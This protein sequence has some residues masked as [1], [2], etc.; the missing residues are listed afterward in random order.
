[1]AS[2][3]R[4]A[5]A[6]TLALG[7]AALA[8]EYVTSTLRRD[9]MSARVASPA[10]APPPSSES[11]QRA[12]SPEPTAV[13]TLKVPSLVGDARNAIAWAP[14]SDPDDV[15]VEGSVPRS[16]AW[17][18]SK[19]LVIA[20]YLGTVVGGDPTRIPGQERIWIRDALAK[21]DGPAI[22]A[23]KARIPGGPGPAMTRILRSVGDV[24]TVAPNSYEGTMQWTVREQVRFMA[25]LG[26][27][28][29]VSPAASA[30][31]LREMQP[32]PE[33]RW[34]LGSI[35]ARAFKPGWLRAN[36][37]TRQMGI[38]GN[39]AVAI[40]TAGDGPAMLQGDGDYAHAA[41]MDRLAGIVAARIG[42]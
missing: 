3:R 8:T 35:G 11:A 12:A 41:Q 18:T 10:Y 6:L 40:I 9:T 23:I 27:G 2:A 22:A 34:G 26:N 42:A 16:R 30:Y 15:T 37:E 4:L 36:S 13:Q 21:S 19:V 17:S 20:A 38:V 14:L 29:V 25:A 7:T 31:L 1:M 33:Q 24:T 5:L 28:R 32:I 39:F